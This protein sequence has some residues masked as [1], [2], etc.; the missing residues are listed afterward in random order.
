MCL[1]GAENKNYSGG[2]F[3]LLES[4]KKNGQQ[5]QEIQNWLK[6]KKAIMEER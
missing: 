2:N 6:C 5:C 1:L 4:S 3:E